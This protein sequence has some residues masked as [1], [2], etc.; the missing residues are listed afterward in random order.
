MTESIMVL[1]IRSF[2]DGSWIQEYAAGEMYTDWV[3]RSMFYFGITS[4][5]KICDFTSSIYK[6][7]CEIK[8]VEV[9]PIYRC[10]KCGKPTFSE[11]CQHGYF[12]GKYYLTKK[13]MVQSDETIAREKLFQNNWIFTRLV[14]S[15]YG[16]TSSVGS[17]F[18]HVLQLIRKNTVEPCI[19]LLQKLID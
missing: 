8:I 3:G 15:V 13:I 5:L 4:L 7:M 17:S 19:V 16:L 1:G 10:I 12:G 18:D 6:I 2:K 9:Q 14:D 11:V